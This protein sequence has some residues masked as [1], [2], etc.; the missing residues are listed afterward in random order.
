MAVRYANH[1]LKTRQQAWRFSA[2]LIAVLS[3]FLAWRFTTHH[4]TVAFSLFLMALVPFALAFQASR[5]LEAQERIHSEPTPEME[6]VFRFVANT[7]L[8]FSGIMLA[9]LSALGR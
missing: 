8:A 6:F 4:F 9:L 2:V 1:W 5:F 7:P 3:P